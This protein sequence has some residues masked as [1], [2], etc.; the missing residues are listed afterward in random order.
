MNLDKYI[1][2]LQ[3]IKEKEGGDLE[4]GRILHGREIEPRP[5][6]GNLRKCQ[7]RESR[8]WTWAEHDGEERKGKRLLLI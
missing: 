7:G 4:V 2:I 6:I 8:I 5:R 1:E 3:S